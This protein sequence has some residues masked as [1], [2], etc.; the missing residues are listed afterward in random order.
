MTITTNTFLT[1]SAIGNRED[2]QDKIWNISPT[3]TP[4]QAAI[5]KTKA[6]AVL[7]EWQRDSLDAAAANAQLE[8]DDSST[9][10]W[11]K[12]AVPTVRINNRC[13][14]SAKNVIV[15]GTQDAVSKAGRK[16][17]ITL[18]LLKRSKELKRDCE[19]VLLNNQAPAT[20]SSTVARALR[21]LNS[22]YGDTSSPPSSANVQRGASGASG[23]STT[24]ATDGT[25]RA[26]TESLL[27]SAIQ[28]AV[29]NGGD[30][31]FIMSGPFNKTVIS[32]FSGNNTR[33]QDTSDGRLNTAIDVYVSDFGTHKVRY[34]RFSR[35][36]DLHVID[37]A[38]LAVAELRP[39]TT[40]DLAKTGDSEKGY[41][42]REFTLECRNDAG[43][44]VVADLTTS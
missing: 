19:F 41:M 17:E 13:Q 31:D 38:L 40:I 28:G 30:P 20:G 33:M 23:S 42:L 16:R 24:A 5:G 32:T 27:K 7:H 36:R 35:D 6:P 29:T 10:S 8:G 2:L 14:I 11:F 22:W 15:S 1:F 37:R 3:D 4:L 26:L 25:Q 44:G 18:Q 43:L 12:A 34:N 9:A 21:P 39:Y